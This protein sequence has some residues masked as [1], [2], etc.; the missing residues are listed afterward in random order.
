[1]ILLVGVGVFCSAAVATSRD[2]AAVQISCVGNGRFPIPF[3]GGYVVEFILVDFGH[4]F[5]CNHFRS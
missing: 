3:G 5:K 2:E 4:A 1:M